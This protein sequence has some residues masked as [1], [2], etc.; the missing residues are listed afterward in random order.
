MD[1]GKDKHQVLRGNP[2]ADKVVNIKNAVAGRI[3]AQ[4][5]QNKVMTKQGLAGFDLAHAAHV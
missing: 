1:M 4:E 5:L 3:G 2:V